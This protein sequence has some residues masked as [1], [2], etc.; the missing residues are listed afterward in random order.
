MIDHRGK[1]F[2]GFGRGNVRQGRSAN[3]DHLDA[4]RPRRGDLAVGRLAAAVLG[5]DDIDAVVPKQGVFVSLPE[6]PARQR[7]SAS[8]TASFGSTGSTLRMR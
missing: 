4:Q 1:R 8:G 2:D 3:H 5:H 7:Y 6:W